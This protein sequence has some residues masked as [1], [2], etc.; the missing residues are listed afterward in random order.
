MALKNAI[1][2]SLL[3]VVALLGPLVAYAGVSVIWPESTA[4]VDVD[5]NPPVQFAAGADH[6]TAQSLGFAGAFS[7][8]DNG[9]S[10]SLTLNGL[11]GGTVTIDDLANIT[12]DASISSYKMEVTAAPTGIT[13]DTLKIRLWTGASAPTADGDAQ[14][15]AVLDL[16]A[17]GESANACSNS[18]KM[19][20]IYALPSG[21]T[22]ET[23]TVTI[24]PS[25]LVFA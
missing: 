13:P 15:C 4:T 21:Q 8:N 14:V 10:Y 22:T 25:S 9:A 7:T 17:T 11:S 6:A 16:T 3:I 24:R 5:E 12:R 2:V 1:F 20:L 23:G 19:Q 18:V